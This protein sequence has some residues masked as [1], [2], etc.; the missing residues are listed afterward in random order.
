MRTTGLHTYILNNN[1]KSVGVLVCFMVVVQMM[2]AAVWACCAMF[3]GATGALET[4]AAL[5]WTMTIGHALPVAAATLV[6]AG[7]ALAYFKH[8]IRD[9]TG[10][11]PAL[12]EHERRLY[13]CVENL[14]IATGLTPPRIEISESPALNAFAMGLS[15]HRCTIGVTRGLLQALSDSELE[16]V[17]AHELAHIRAHDVRLMTIATI[18]SGIV[19]STGWF[20]TYRLREIFRT[21]QKR[22]LAALPVLMACGVVV[23]AFGK[24]FPW[25]VPAAFAGLIISALMISLSL[26]F[27]L[28]RSR[29]IVA[30]LAACE[31]TKNP[32]ALISALLKIE[33]RNLLP[34]CETAVQAMMISAPSDGYFASHP[35]LEHRIDAIVTY[36][37]THLN[38]LRLAA[39]AQRHMPVDPVN[40]ASATPDFS[41][42]A[43][44]YPA[45]VSKPLIVIPALAVGL[46]VN[47]MT[48][49][50]LAW[51]ELSVLQT[52]ELRGTI[53]PFDSAGDWRTLLLYIGVPLAVSLVLRLVR[54]AFSSDASDEPTPR[55]TQLNI[56]VPQPTPNQPRVF[57][58]R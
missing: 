25:Y 12:R 49:S 43:L 11:H 28:S 37:A 5:V 57:G 30:D 39:A 33:G 1:L 56:S 10:L 4:Y 53:L 45:W 27:A 38:G 7:L 16:S 15:T 34:L 9:M 50:P 31:L 48:A 17:I 35:K 20:L 46:A 13:D 8:I 26:R 52:V 22:P 3:Y 2:F 18:F 51:P 14:S 42:T 40:D 44:Q 21:A 55:A 41:I 24:Q 47:S 19:F 6:W 54:V 58:K 23:L 32:E 36:A 29:E